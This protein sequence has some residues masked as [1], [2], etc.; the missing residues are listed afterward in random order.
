MVESSSTT[1]KT[2][3]YL[4][5]RKKKIKIQKTSATTKKSIKHQQNQQKK[6]IK[7]QNQQKKTNKIDKNYIKKTIK[8]PEN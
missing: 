7:W 3:K 6:L 4:E 8:H 5:N 2:R 1:K